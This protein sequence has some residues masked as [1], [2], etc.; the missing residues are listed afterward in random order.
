M[1]EY[2]KRYVRM[3]TNLREVAE[4]VKGRLSTEEFHEIMWLGRNTYKHGLSLH[5]TEVRTV[6]TE[7]LGQETD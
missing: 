6:L 7:V 3:R 4:K 1:N 2:D 5:P